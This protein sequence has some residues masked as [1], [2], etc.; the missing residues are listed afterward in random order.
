MSHPFA[1]YNMFEGEAAILTEITRECAALTYVP[2]DSSLTIVDDQHPLLYEQTFDEE[3]KDDA[4]NRVVVQRVGR[5]WSECI[6]HMLDEHRGIYIPYCREPIYLNKPIIMRS[7]YT[8]KIHPDNE[9]RLKPGT[10]TC[11]VRNESIVSG[12]KQ[13]VSQLQVQPDTRIHIEGGT[14]TTLANGRNGGNG[15]SRG[16]ADFEGSVGGMFGVIVLHNTKHVTVRNLVI[17]ECS[18]FGIQ[19]GNTTNLLVE[20]IQYVDH[21][22]DGVHLEGPLR[23]GIVRNISGRTGD[24]VVAL[25]AWDWQASSVTFGSIENVLVERV[26]SD[27]GWAELRLLPGTKIF[28]DGQTQRCEINNCIFRYIEGIH[29]IKMY[30]QPN[31]EMGRDRDYSTEVGSMDNLYFSD[32][33][34]TP[35]VQPN[36]YCAKDA[37]FEVCANVGNLYLNSIELRDI[38][39]Q[40]SNWTKNRLLAVGPMSSLYKVI[41]GGQECWTELFRPEFSCA[42]DHLHVKQ[43]HTAEKFDYSDILIERWKNDEKKGTTAKGVIRHIHN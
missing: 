34:F 7:N 12:A 37:F 23:N 22:R 2:D 17:K 36:H 26:Q 10:N 4:G 6:Q 20:N 42:I 15:N 1:Q 16:H 28:P 35:F 40:M 3:T 8:L 21:H 18:Y 24:D 38:H 30:D 39:K 11:M 41:R 31:L 19:I 13:P 14:W 43:L 25:N 9:I 5:I 27:H 29:T 32:I 33:V